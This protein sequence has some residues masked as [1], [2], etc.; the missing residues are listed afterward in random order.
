MLTF[1]SP[2][3]LIGSL[4]AAVP[5]VLHLLKREPEPRVKFPAVRLLKRA[6][7]EYTEKRH[8]RELVLL[9]LRVA[10]LILL[11]VAFARPFLTSATAIGSTG[12]TIV[13][14][15]TS[16]SMSAPGAFDRAKALARTAVNR[17]GAGDLVGVITFSDAPNVAVA[18]GP[19]RALA[20]AAIESATPGF[21]ATRYR[22]AVSAAVQALG[23][24]RGTIV[25]VT[26][27][28]ESGWDAGER[29]SVPES[30]RIELLD[31]G[32]V[33]TNLAVT[34]LRVE[35]DRVIATIRNSGAAPRDAR[36]HLALDGRT[37]GEATVAVGGR[38]S[39]DVELPGAANATAVA[40]TVDDRDGL[41]ADNARY[42]LLDTTTRPGVLVITSSGDQGREGFYVR[43]ALSAAGGTAPA[44]G[45]YQPTGMTATQLSAVDASRLATNVA[46]ML[47]S[48]RGLERRGRETLAKYIKGGGGLLIAA[49]PDIDSEIVADVLGD[50]LP[51]RVAAV[52]DGPPIERSLI[53]GDVRHP[54]FRAFGP[55]AATLGLVKFRR[56]ARIDGVGCQA[57]ARFTTGETALLDCPAGEGHAIVLASDLDN[58]WN[59]FP[60]RATF[61]PFLHETL[62]YL[63]SGRPQE[64]QYLIAD[65]PA[66]V[67]PV[68]GIATIQPSGGTGAVRRVAVNVD[69]RESDLA[70]LSPD[71]FQSAVT[72]LKDVGV[73]EAK[74]ET[75]QRE[76]R[77][78]LWTYVL[79]L[80]VAL[81]A[82]EGIVASRTA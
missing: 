21:G 81:L 66:G 6:P 32:P 50:D 10:M 27:L 59:D 60:L 79:A 30:A 64:G 17:A 43:Q 52:P 39:V 19:D 67:P 9:A 61:V 1:L 15:D 8:L 41:T 33:P 42:A 26:D 63:G 69:P 3:F 74:V 12:A 5:I 38:A 40:V 14:L 16:Y 24:R 20:L 44:G 36:T 58:R 55:D 22:G 34:A 29:T 31:V 65:V 49:G 53:P 23:G 80:T 71:D 72:R 37:A 57:V 77:Q 47:L 51:L 46:V 78:H 28:Q 13:A 82:V 70:R 76:D 11:A 18:P 7:V 2:L 35:G 62:G 25:V 54:V 4:A 45:A 56:V 75:E 68:P 48:T 73:A